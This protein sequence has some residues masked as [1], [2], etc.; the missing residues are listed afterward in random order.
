MI[1]VCP[2]CATRY[3]VPDSAIGS[4]GRQVRCAN[5]RHSWFQ[6]APVME[7]PVAAA[8]PSAPP[9]APV[10]P[11]ESAP[12]EFPPI[13]RSV[14]EPAPETSV[15]AKPEP[16]QDIEDAPA[17]AAPLRAAPPVFDDAPPAYDEEEA[18]Q[19][20]PDVPFRPRRNPARLWTMAAVLFFLAAAGVGGWVYMFG[21]PAWAVNL[22]LV[23]DSG[24]N[25]LVLDMP[26]KPE[27]R[28]LP[29]GSDYF[30]FSGRVV[31]ASDQ[32]QPVPP[33]LVELRD[34]QNR[35]VF[36]WTMKPPVARLAA[37]AQSS[38]FESRLDIPK[39]AQSLTLTF[40]DAS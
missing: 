29:N 10:P 15:E 24:N 32:T 34:P 25:G 27:R 11:P 28:T 21:I 18:S 1:L 22:G 19:Y 13:A 6:D 26:R 14:A 38:F 8:Q 12:P 17:A 39:N 7:R 20:D 36:G 5:C 40:S 9:P 2:E 30:A 31:N 23:P 4:S 35:L 16:E 37:G 3:V 33:I